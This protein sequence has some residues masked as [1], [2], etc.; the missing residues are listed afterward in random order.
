MITSQPEDTTETHYNTTQL[1]QPVK[2]KKTKQNVIT[3]TLRRS[4]IVPT[5]RGHDRILAYTGWAEKVTPLWYFGWY[6]FP[7]LLGELY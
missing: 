1:S 5:S 6:E 2:I 7:L 3:V 4:E